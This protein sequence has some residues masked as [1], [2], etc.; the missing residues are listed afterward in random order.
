MKSVNKAIS[1]IS[2]HLNEVF[3]KC[4]NQ[5]I[6]LSLVSESGILDHHVFDCV[7]V[8]EFRPLIAWKICGGGQRQDFVQYTHYICYFYIQI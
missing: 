8:V 1:S 2:L 7:L 4:R 3:Q 6:T 5:V